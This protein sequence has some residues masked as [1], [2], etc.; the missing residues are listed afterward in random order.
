MPRYA[1][2]GLISPRPDDGSLLVDLSPGYMLP[3]DYAA[4]L[5]IGSD[6]MAM[7]NDHGGPGASKPDMDFSS[8]AHAE[9][10]ARCR[11]EFAE[12]ES[13]AR[14]WLRERVQAA[15][16]DELKRQTAAYPGFTAQ[17]TTQPNL[18]VVDGILSVDELASATVD[19]FLAM[20]S[21][22]PAMVTD[23]D[24]VTRVEQR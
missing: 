10:E 24:G 14:A 9:A 22:P 1:T 6:L 5:G 15:L 12:R 19:V 18:F 4:A 23:Q 2:G 13:K 17:T 20:L 7:P 16:I 8:Q 11:A 21:D 3:A